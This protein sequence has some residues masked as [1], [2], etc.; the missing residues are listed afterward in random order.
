[1]RLL[2]Y[3]S[4][5]YYSMIVMMVAT[6]AALVVSIVYYGRHRELRIFTYYIAFSL[7][8]DGIGICSFM[9]PDWR[10]AYIPTSI[11]INSFAIFEFII[12]HLFILHYITSPIRKS[13]LKINLFVYPALLAFIMIKKYPGSI[14]IPYFLIGNIFMVI[15][16]LFY[17]YELF[18]KVDLQPLKDQPAFWIVTAFLFHSACSIPYALTGHFL[19]KYQVAATTVVYLLYSIVFLF[20]IRANLCRPEKSGSNPINKSAHAG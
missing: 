14:Y 18:Q 15:P 4:Q 13:I 5:C 2:D 10:A 7:V 16:C 12:C 20:I 1:L 17:F 6:V 3:L 19:G 9:A 11:A 8:E